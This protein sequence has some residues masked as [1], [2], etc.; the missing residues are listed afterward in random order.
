[1][2]SFAARRSSQPQ[3]LSLAAVRSPRSAVFCR[4][5]LAAFSAARRCPKSS[6]PQFSIAVDVLRCSPQSAIAAFRH[7]PQLIA[8]LSPESWCSARSRRKTDAHHA[9]ALVRI[10]I[11]GRLY[12]TGAHEAVRIG[13]HTKS[14]E[15][16]RTQSRQ[17]QG[18]YEVVRIK[19]HTKSS[20]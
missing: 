3:C 11:R 4:S 2:Q 8:I 6:T 13:A 16:G 7:S 5:P 1:M 20:E 18:A 10:T 12:S 19:A 9:H 17:N 14:S 15:Y